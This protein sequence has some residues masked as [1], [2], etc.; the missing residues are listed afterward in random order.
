MDKTSIGQWEYV[1][2]EVVTNPIHT[3]CDLVSNGL[4]YPGVKLIFRIFAT[5]LYTCIP[6]RLPNVESMFPKSILY[7]FYTV[8]NNSNRDTLK[9]KL[10]SMEYVLALA[11]LYR[12]LCGN[13]R[14]VMI[15]IPFVKLRS[16]S[17][18]KTLR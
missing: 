18:I 10:D 14:I 3:Q 7:P 4:A 2:T 15:Q 1:F 8:L 16:R 9:K 6:M 13:G 17:S 12:N 11:P 5:S